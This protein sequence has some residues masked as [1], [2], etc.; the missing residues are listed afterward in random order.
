MKAKTGLDDQD[1]DNRKRLDHLE[2]NILTFQN[3]KQIFS[4]CKIFVFIKCNRNT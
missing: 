2:V 4:Y 1:D 3:L